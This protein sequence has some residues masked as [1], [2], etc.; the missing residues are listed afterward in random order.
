MWMPMPSSLQNLKLGIG[1]S[2]DDVFELARCH[3]DTSRTMTWPRDPSNDTVWSASVLSGLDQLLIF[4]G[5]LVSSTS[6]Q[7]T[8]RTVHHQEWEQS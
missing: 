7:S 6:V 5:P 4:I 8:D 2:L 3:A 1:L